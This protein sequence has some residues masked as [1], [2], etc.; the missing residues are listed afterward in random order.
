MVAYNVAN[1]KSKL[2]FSN[3]FTFINNFD[4]F[5]LFETHVVIEERSK[6][7]HF[8]NDYILYWEDAKK[9]HRAGRASGGCLFGFRKSMRSMYSLKFQS[10]ANKVYLSARFSDINYKIIPIYLNCNKWNDEFVRL[11]EFLSEIRTSSFCIIGDFNARLGNAQILD[12]NLLSNSP[13][14]SNLRVSKDLVFNSEGKKLL[15][16]IEN[17]GGIVLNGRFGSGLSGDFT[18][19]GVMGKSVIDYC[20]CSS[21]FLPIISSFDIPPK[22]FSDHMPLILNISALGNTLSKPLTLP[23]KLCWFP[24]NSNRYAENLKKLSSVEYTQSDISMN[25]K[26]KIFV[27]KI[28]LANDNK[29]KNKYFQAKQPWYDC[30]CH[31]AGVTMFELL[32]EYRKN[33]SPLVKNA[34]FVSKVKYRKICNERKTKYKNDNIKKL[35]EVTNISEWWKLAN[36]MKHSGPRIGNA[37][38]SEDFHDHFRNLLSLNVSEDSIAWCVPNIVDPFLDSPFELREL[39]SVLRN[40]KINKSPGK[41]RIPYEFFIN[42]PADFINE[43]LSLF[44]VIYLREDIPSSFHESIIIPLF[45][46]GDV[47]V[48]TNYRGLSLLDT[49]YKLF[50]GILLSRINSWISCNDILNEYQAG[51]RRGY[52]TIDNIFNLTSIVN[53]MFHEKKKLYAFFV[54]FSCAFDLIPRNSLFYKLSSMGLS[55]KMVKILSLLYMNTSSQVWDGCC[56]SESFLVTQG[57]KQGCLLSPVLFSLYVNDLNECLGGGVHVAGTLV[58][59]LLYADDLVILAETTDDLQQMINSLHSYCEKWSLNINLTKSKIVPFRKSSGFSSS[60]EWYYGQEIIEIVKEYK[61]LGV[62][63]SYNLSFVK[64]LESKLEQAKCAINSTWLSYMYNPKIS[65]TNKMKIFHT[66]AKSI[67][68]YGAQVWGFEK[69]DSVEKLF[70]FFV[71]KILFLPNNTPNYMLHLE[72]GLDSQYSETLKLHCSYIAKV[73]CL[74]DNRLPYILAK[75]TMALNLTWSR[76]WFE[77]CGELGIQFHFNCH[78]SLIR[79]Q[80]DFVLREMVLKEQRSNKLKAHNSQNHDFYN[81]LLYDVIP[82]VSDK[83]SPYFTSIIFRTRGGLLNLNARSFNTSSSKL[84]ILCNLNEEENVL[85]FVGRCPIFSYN[86]SLYFGKTVL[87]EVEF[88]EIMNGKNYYTLFKYIICCLKYRDFI[89]N[90]CY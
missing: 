35:N 59:V 89:I 48:V 7:C 63:L 85:H 44:N 4:I 90:D 37:L 22:T 12:T 18:F 57:V 38:S 46:K 40:A 33:D 16:L 82:Y 9:T 43:M 73:L 17:Y 39:I 25:E 84:C 29:H 65:W 62:L 28:Y 79:T 75:A 2:N 3:F 13:L 11:E 51:F 31:S 19:C 56:L 67:M 45:K 32:D 1:L 70:R 54:D 78:Y 58:K 81:K 15:E 49:S 36:L 24:Q 5:F 74:P 8:F 69:F 53:L 47:N 87:N 20:I 76:K 83:N 66:A 6:F 72:T 55:T 23:E 52:S 34:L 88:L 30:K 71:K 21:D 41:D 42:A 14:I 68:C 60:I 26:H 64:H 50:T 27:D 10:I 86:R 61:Y 80:Q 77:L